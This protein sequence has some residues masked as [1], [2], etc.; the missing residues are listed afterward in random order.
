MVATRRARP[1]QRPFNDF[2]DSRDL[3][4]SDDDELVSPQDRR[5][6]RST[7]S[8]RSRVM[9]S[10][11]KPSP[12]V[13]E[14][15]ESSDDFGPRRRPQNAPTLKLM[16]RATRSTANAEPLYKDELLESSESDSMPPRLGKRKRG[17]VNAGP[18]RKSERSGRATKSMREILEDDIPDAVTRASSKSAPKVSAVKESFKP[19]PK[20]N[21]FRLRHCQSCDV[22]N[23]QGD[24]PEKGNLVCCQGCTL[25]YHSSCLG[26]RNG[27]E[28]LVTKVGI[29]DFVLQ[30]RRC[31]E[32]ALKK[33]LT[34]PHQSKCQECGK[35]G[36]SCKAFR[37]R[38]TPREE[39]K[40][41]EEND[42]EDPIV[43]IPTAL[44]NNPRNVMFRCIACYQAFHMHH[45]PSKSQNLIEPND[46]EQKAAERFSWYCQSWMCN[47]C[48][49]A[50]AEIGGL[51]AWRP[52][53][54]E[55][56]T[57]GRAVDEVPEDDKEY[58]VKWSNK[59]FYR[60]TWKRG[61]WVWGTTHKAMR[62]AFARRDNGTNLPTM[63]T[64]DA[65]PEDYLRVDVVLEVKYNNVVNT[66][67]QEVDLARIKEIESARV[68]FK[69]LGYEDVVWEE[70]PAPEDTERWADFK[71]AYEDWVRGRYI[72]VP[73]TT[74]MSASI[75]K[76]KAMNFE[77]KVMLKEQ[78]KS[79]KGGD[80]MNYQLD[81]LNWLLYQWHRDQNAILADEM[82]LG[83]TI[84][85]IAFVATLQ[86]KYNCWPFL[87]IVPNSTC[88]NWRREIKQWAPSLRVVT[89]FGS[90]KAKELAYKYELFPEKERAT[91][92]RCHA[93]VTSYDAAQDEAC[94]KVFKRI[95]WAAL[96]V[97]E[98]QRLKNDSSLLYNAISALRIPFKLLL[99]GTPLQNNQRELFNLLQFL[100]ASIDAQEL[101]EKYSSL[102]K[103]NVTELHNMVRPFF[104]RRTKA[105]VL[106]FLPPMAQIIVP[107][108]MSA[109]QKH[110]YKSILAKNSD[111]LKSV[112]G[113]SKRAPVTGL[114]N[115][116]MQLRKC[117][118][119]PF[120]YSL[121]IEEKSD[122]ALAS[123]RRLVEASSKLQLLE[124]MLP[125]L[126]ERGHR[127][128]IFSQFLGMLTIIEDFLAGLG[129]EHLRLD[130][131][132][133]SLAKQKCIDTFN[134]PD[135]SVFA[136]LL[137]TRAGGV[138]INLAT[139]DTV[140]ILDPDFNPHQDIQA[141]S[142][143]HRI[144]Q[145]KKVLIF[146]MM[147]RGSAEE[148]I[149]QMGKKKMALDHV[150]IEQMDADEADE[151]DLE[152]VLRFGAEAL[153]NDDDTHDI[154]YDSTSVDKLLDRSQIEDTEI[155]KDSSAQSQFSFAKIW[156]NESGTMEEGL[157][158]NSEEEV[159]DDG[160]LWNKILAERARQAEVDRRLK[161]ETLGRGKRQRKVGVF[162]LWIFTLLISTDCRLQQADNS[163][164]HC[165]GRLAQ[166]RNGH[167][168]PDSR[169]E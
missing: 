97:D 141:I 43:V 113:G 158:G 124:I 77:A 94:Q 53:D 143:A 7:R 166:R 98:G 18:T 38:K 20:T 58:L 93:V 13:L 161:A 114:R 60:S 155:G 42:G 69:G 86:E 56:Y 10:M 62:L 128:L 81:G 111:L 165:R 157:L 120:V 28:H 154:H 151:N 84:Q 107:V 46:E 64:E 15:T 91:D 47:D 89:Y 137:S 169:G 116:L 147:T 22:C 67:I 17:T 142:R 102:N 156:Q 87:I 59:S 140:I 100:D 73:S 66:R 3:Q 74:T 134:A 11:S 126:K 2:L 106:T 149:M 136:F 160:T 55:S 123:H 119:H 121:D 104:L 167:G 148:K 75:K 131:T 162:I 101:E 78:P 26:S 71:A 29:G 54:I 150:L 1:I 39:Q 32:F 14:S 8:T 145:K 108:T 115:I 80:L 61:P 96:I 112:F 49:T 164:R 122:E 57:A 109:L 159:E 51:V 33:D 44:I 103:E 92:L 144:G 135:S 36:P 83:K 21:D 105:Q 34:A 76:L 37:E 125:K 41:R 146:Q 5:N 129:L 19:L 35:S 82:G 48:L 139:A 23:E 118:C 138:G 68:K 9:R 110:L 127:V 88:A 130:G 50:P 52:R 30:C 90:A 27:R 12:E 24:I 168:F 163:R 99:T 40:D 70:P 85:V 4:L 117:L 132:M 6:T 152:S 63:R 45:L 31:V 25:S 153:F 72:R 65:I 133:G 16:L 95:N 79:L